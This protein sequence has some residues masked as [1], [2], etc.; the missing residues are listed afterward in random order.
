MNQIKFWLFHYKM[1]KES[2]PN[3]ALIE[4]YGMVPRKDLL[5]HENHLHVDFPP[6]CWTKE[7]KNLLA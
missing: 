4:K 2:F 5:S 3:F 7:H 1:T 6:Y